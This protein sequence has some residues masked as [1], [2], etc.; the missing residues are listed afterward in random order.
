MIV[1]GVLPA[2]GEAQQ[3]DGGRGVPVE[4]VVDE[5]QVAQ[6]LR[7]PDAVDSDGADLEPGAGERCHPG[8]ALGEQTLHRVVGE[9]QVRTAGV[10]VDAGAE[11]VEHHRCALCVPAGPPRTPRARPAHPALAD[12]SRAIDTGFSDAAVAVAGTPDRHVERIIALRV[13]RVVVELGGERDRLVHAEAR[14]GC[15][16]GGARVDGAVAQIRVAAS[17][18]S[19]PE[20]DHMGDGRAGGRFVVGRADAER[21]HA[22]VEGKAPDRGDLIVGHADPA[23]LGEHRVIHVGDVAC[24]FHSDAHTPPD[25]DG[26]IRPQVGG[27]VTEVRDVVGSD[28]ADVHPGPTDDRQC[29]AVEPQGIPGKRCEGIHMV[30]VPPFTCRL[31]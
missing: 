21:G 22:P 8:C 26:E 4:Q 31:I 15:G 2:S 10:Q 16:V 1:P 29:G 20:L 9:T 14:M 25:P 23:G 5:R 27:R 19:L 28:P 7:H 30:R 11:R 3:A 13:V 6:R 17:E 24:D 18:Q 12:A